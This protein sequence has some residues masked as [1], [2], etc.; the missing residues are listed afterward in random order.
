MGLAFFLMYCFGFYAGN[1]SGNFEGQASHSANQ[2]A[3]D[4]KRI[5]DGCFKLAGKSATSECIADAYKSSH[6]NQRAEYDLKVQRDMSDWA[7]WTMIIGALQF[8]A[9]IATLGFVKLTL[10]ATLAAVKDT[11]KATQAMLKQ[12]NLAEEAQRPWIRL[13]V[14]AEKMRLNPNGDA[15][16]SFAIHLTNVGATPAHE[17]KFGFGTELSKAKKVIKWGSTIL[18]G[19]SEIIRTGCTIPKDIEAPVIFVMIKY[20]I[21]RIDEEGMALF[22]GIVAIPG[23]GGPSALKRPFDSREFDKI[24]ISRIMSFAS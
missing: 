2:Y 3:D 15:S 4:T 11:S 17:I 6:E 12:N 18:P 8:L 14:D 9:T 5:I 23:Q 24:Y 19:D 13:K 22:Q 7:W 16:L 1:A 21:Q 10:D 20:E